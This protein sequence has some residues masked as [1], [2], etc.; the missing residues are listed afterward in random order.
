MPAAQLD[1]QNAFKG[2]EK[3]YQLHQTLHLKRCAH[4]WFWF[5]VS[6]SG[7]GITN[8]ERY[9]QL[10]RLCSFAGATVVPSSTPQIYRTSSMCLAVFQHA[11]APQMLS[12]F[13]ASQATFPCH[14]RPRAWSR[15]PMLTACTPVQ[16]AL[17]SQGG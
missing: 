12:S 13:S 11:R 10:Q 6:S 9:P 8:R 5:C 7:S 14:P 16:A 1:S 3:H 17:C 2:A 4:C 15:V